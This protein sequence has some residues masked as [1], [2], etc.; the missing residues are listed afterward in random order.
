MN[1]F[2]P[3]CCALLLGLTKSNCA[4]LCPLFVDQRNHRS[5]RTDN[6]TLRGALAFDFKTRAAIGQEHEA[7][8][9]CDQVRTRASD[10]LG[11]FRA[12]VLPKKSLKP[13]VCR[14]TGQNAM[15]PRRLSRTR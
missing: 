11:R 9:P 10:N 8:G 15:V 2:L 5:I 6:T 7:R 3:S 13:F 4:H 12:W 14:M 1:L